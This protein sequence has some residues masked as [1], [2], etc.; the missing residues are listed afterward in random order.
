MLYNRSV[1]WSIHL[2][3]DKKAQVRVMPHF[4]I[5]LENF[6]SICGLKLLFGEGFLCFVKFLLVLLCLF[7]FIFPLLVGL[8]NVFHIF[9]SILLCTFLFL[10]FPSCFIPTT[11]SALFILCYG[12]TLILLLHLSWFCSCVCSNFAHVFTPTLPMCLFWFHS[13]ISAPCSLLCH[14]FNFALTSIPT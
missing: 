9:F 12:S 14:S 6:S 5:L 4:A 2:H 13:C 7:S 8:C 1:A 3:K 10:E 11:T